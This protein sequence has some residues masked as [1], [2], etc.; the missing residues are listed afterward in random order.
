MDFSPEAVARY[1]HDTRWQY[2]G[3]WSKQD[4]LA[5]H[6][7]YWD[8]S[9]SNH[10]QALRRL[11]EVLANT[12]K[13]SASD[14]VLDAGCGWGGSSLWLAAQ[15]GAQCHGISIESDQIDVARN[16]AQKK[17]VTSRAEFS[18]RDFTDTGFPD[19][20]FDVVWAVE[21]VCH[22]QDKAAFAREALRVLKPGGRLILSDFFR[23]HREQSA[24]DEAHLRSWFEKWVVPDLATFEEFASALSGAGFTEHNISDITD[25][26][27]P[28]ADRL[29]R[30]GRI[31]APLAKL[32]RFLRIHNDMQDANWRSSLSQY[33]T[34][35]AG[36][37]RYGLV[38][39]H[40]AR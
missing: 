35:Q 17:G 12:A 22:A 32:F 25:N 14:K 21:S 26:I 6:Y 27:R 23:S 3:L 7:G 33:T 34:L 13:I 37:W 28:S 30:T 39:A 40:K 10:A 8:G 1:Y 2:Y 24:D 38:F 16:M 18:Q 20:S 36:L 11:N 31:T 5:L 15:R 9:V 19:H 4:S 29:H